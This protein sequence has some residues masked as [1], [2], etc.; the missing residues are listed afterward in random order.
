MKN[1]TE[2]GHELSQAEIQLLEQLREHPEMLERLR[3]ILDLMCPAE[4]PLK[5]ADEVEELLIQELRRLGNTSMNQWAKLAEA[6]VSE[7]LR[8]QDPTLRSRK[9]K[10]LKWGCVFGEVAVRDRI[11]RSPTQK[12]LRPLPG[13]LG[14]TPRGRSRRLQRALTDFGCEHSFARAAERVLEHYGLMLG[15]TAVRTA[16]LVHAERARVKLEAQYAQPFRVLP[17]VGAEHVIVEA[18]GTLICTVAPGPRKG[19]RP[20]GWQEMRL[21]AGQAKDSATTFY[22]ATFGS[23]AQT[24]RRWGHCARQAGWG[25][26][27]HI[28]AL[29][30]GAEWIPIQC[31]EVFGEQATFTCDFYH[32]SGYLGDA[33]PSCRPAQPHQWRRTQQQRLR[34][35]DVAKVLAALAEH[36]EPVGTVEEEAPVRNAQRYVT[37]RKDSLDY[38]RALALGLPIGSGMIESG[39]RHVLQARL[40]KAGTA[41]LPDH[42]DQ[43]AHLR[44]LRANHQWESLWN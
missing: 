32:V 34:R 30:D 27:S 36:L 44:V 25:L 4:G 6:R 12:Y 43:I 29:G 28:H 14:V 2:G 18:D 17:A 16:T 23:V 10:V 42:A 41:W 9:K 5:S 35:G 11:W 21:V 33:A 1:P 7:E 38:P 31:R 13:R 3:R 20:R 19:K 39:H 40:K 26:N 24:G 37:N 8:R 15:S 22:G